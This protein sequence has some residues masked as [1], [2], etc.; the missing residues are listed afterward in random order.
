MPHRLCT[1]NKCPTVSRP[2]ASYGAGSFVNCNS[3]QKWEKFL[4]VTTLL[5]NNVHIL[6]LIN[7][8]NF[9]IIFFPLNSIQ[10]FFKIFKLILLIYDTILTVSLPQNTMHKWRMYAFLVE[11]TSLSLL[12]VWLTRP[13]TLSRSPNTHLP[14]LLFRET[15]LSF[16]RLSDQPG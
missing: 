1:C 14:R 11:P 5:C 8:I 4:R 6:I 9:K 7:K 13:L 2:P 12:A 16:P 3:T 15:I 10:K